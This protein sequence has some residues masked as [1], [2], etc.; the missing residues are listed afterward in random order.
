[1]GSTVA[2]ETFEANYEIYHPIAQKMVANDL[3]V[4]LASLSARNSQKS[5]DSSPA[6]KSPQGGNTSSNTATGAGAPAAA[7]VGVDVVGEEDDSSLL[8]PMAIAAVSVAAVVA[9]NLF[10]RR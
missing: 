10:K 2:R 4:D 9:F 3:G 1:M 8:I 7:A 5:S 6:N